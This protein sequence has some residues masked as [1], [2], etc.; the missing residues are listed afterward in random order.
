MTT[1][2]MI[3]IETLDTEDTA[4]ILSIGVCKFDPYT[5]QEPHARELWLPSLEEQFKLDRTTSESTLEW[6]S[7]QDPKILERA[8]SETGRQPCINI[9]KEMNKY[10]V[11]VEQ[12]WA[13]GVLFDI[14]IIENL[15]GMLDLHTN[16]AYWQISDSRTIF[17]MMPKDPRKDIQQD[18]HDAAA[19]AY[20]QA[21]CVQKTFAQFGVTPR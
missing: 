21:I 17:N 10:F 20:Y 18:L 2:A 8:L 3:D 5:N 7:K 11:G 6:W 9:L 16:W 15:Y 12:I 19:D 4:I 1:H 13:Q 14:N